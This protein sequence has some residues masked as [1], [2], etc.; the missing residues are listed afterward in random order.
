MDERTDLNQ[1]DP[2]E[3][4]TAPPRAEDERTRELRT[5]LAVSRSI[6][7]PLA[8]GPPPDP[9]RREPATAPAG[10][11]VMDGR[12][13]RGQGARDRLHRSIARRAGLLHPP[14]RGLRVG[15]R[16]SRRRGDRERAAVCAGAGG[17]K[18][19]DRPRTDRLE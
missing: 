1:A 2:P 10:D 14:A 8:L 19:G 18:E 9:S 12:P 3:P 4:A 7:S 13:T 6:P 5:L 15:D 16:Q 11:Q 17:G